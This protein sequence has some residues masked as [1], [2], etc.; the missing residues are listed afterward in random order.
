MLGFLD[1]GVLTCVVLG[2]IVNDVA[3]LFSV[4]ICDNQYPS[5]ANKLGFEVLTQCY[6]KRLK[7]MILDSILHSTILIMRSNSIFITFNSNC[8]NVDCNNQS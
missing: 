7:Q 6:M 2:S 8:N 4:S 5:Q 1:F 3:S